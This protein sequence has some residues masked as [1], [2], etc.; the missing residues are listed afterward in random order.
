MT[1][2]YT[3]LDVYKRQRFASAQDMLTAL[4][5]LERQMG[6]AFTAVEV[7][8]MP[9]PATLA[10]TPTASR[11]GLWLAAM[12]S[13]AAAALGLAYYLQLTA[14]PAPSII[15]PPSPSTAAHPAAS[16]P[17]SPNSPALAAPVTAAAPDHT[18]LGI[19]C[20][21]YTSRCV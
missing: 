7:P 11:R 1:V 8:A 15:Q 16:V 4:E 6:K 9:E 18:D 5:Q 14:P 13:V 10:A 21:L 3:H 12:G 19:T 17:A 20:L 2:S